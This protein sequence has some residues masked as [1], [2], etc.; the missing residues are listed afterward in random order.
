MT[1]T[2]ED[3]DEVGT[4]YASMKSG[5][6]VYKA[7]QVRNRTSYSNYKRSRSSLSTTSNYKRSYTEIYFIF[8]IL[9]L[10]I[11]VAC[12]C[13]LIVSVETKYHDLINR[14]K[15]FD[16]RANR[17]DQGIYTQID[18]RINTI[19]SSLSYHLPQVLHTTANSINGRL[20][21][22]NHELKAL[23][24]SNFLE[25]DVKLGNNRSF[26]LNTGS[27]RRGDDHEKHKEEMDNLPIPT[28]IPPMTNKVN[29][30]SFYPLQANPVGN[31]RVTNH[32]LNQKIEEARLNVKHTENWLKA[33]KGLSYSPMSRYIGIGTALGTMP[34]KKS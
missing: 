23:I 5:I 20:I 1:R 33:L 16:H 3:P 26:T 27:R 6:P 9:L 25:L 17:D 2:Y 31:M 34:K 30:P 21:Q 14:I 29:N 32:D 18:S 19:M 4:E 28:I 7:T 13:Y 15:D 24:R 11:N 10:G 12:T 8:I 22:V